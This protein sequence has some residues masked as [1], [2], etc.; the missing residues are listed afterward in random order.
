MLVKTV[1]ASDLHACDRADRSPICSLND[2]DA[3]RYIDATLYDQVTNV[4]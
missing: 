1:S 4:D 2:R 3:R